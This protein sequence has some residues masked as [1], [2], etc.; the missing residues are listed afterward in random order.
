MFFLSHLKVAWNIHSQTTSSYGH[1]NSYE[2]RFCYVD[3]IYDL[4][5]SLFFV[6]KLLI[7]TAFQTD[8]RE[9]ETDENGC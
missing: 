6:C 7:K 3:F 4:S 9:L 8:S 2:T 1:I 5:M